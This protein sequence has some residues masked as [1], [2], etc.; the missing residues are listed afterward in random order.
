MSE[1]RHT[2]PPPE[3]PVGPAERALDILLAIAV[4]GG[5]GWLVAAVA[6][7]TSR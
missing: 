4:G 5:L 7:T 2:P 6:S 1:H 3:R